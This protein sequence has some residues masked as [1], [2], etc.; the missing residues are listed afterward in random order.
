MKIVHAH[1]SLNTGGT[2]TMM[3]DIMNEQAKTDEVWCLIVNDVVDE[4]V[5]ARLSTRVHFKCYHRKP[6]IFGYLAILKLNFDLLHI[7]PDVI[8]THGEEFARIIIAKKTPIVLTRHS[9][10]GYGKYCHLADQLCFISNAVRAHSVAQGH[11]GIVV[12]NGIHPEEIIVKTHDYKNLSHNYRIVQVG[13]L[14]TIKGQQLLVEAAYKLKKQGVSGFEID[15]I[16][17]GSERKN[18]QNLIEQYNLNDCVHLLG[19]KDRSYVYSHLCEY[20]LFVQASLSEGFGLT[21]AEAM[22]AGVSV[23][24]S[25]LDGPLEVIG[26]GKYGEIFETNNAES[27]SYQLLKFINNEVPDKTK[28]AKRVVWDQFNINH[29]ASRYLSIYKNIQK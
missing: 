16:G 13:R 12:Y 24:S 11:D 3:V 27:L 23:L 2:E 18:L 21:L 19:A 5:Y 20:D 22:A 15:F 29:T 26:Y 6:G 14:E 28:E 10:L 1:W 9:T 7:C 25:N 17:D 8:H 4:R